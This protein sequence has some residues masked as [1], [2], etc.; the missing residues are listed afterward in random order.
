M[1]VPTL[2]PLRH[3][4]GLDG[5]TFLLGIGGMKC[6]TSW[7]FEYLSGLD[8]MTASDIKELHFFN[9]KLRKPGHEPFTER[10]VTTLRDFLERSG[11]VA[12]EIRGNPPF[13]ATVDGLRMLHDDN[14]YF[15]YFARIATPDTKVLSEV[16]PQYSVLGR[17]GFTYIKDFFASQNMNL[18]IFLILRDPV[19]RLWSH[20]R[21]L[22]DRGKAKD[23]LAAWPELIRQRSVIERSDYWQTIEGLDA[24]FPA[25]DVLCLFYED[26]FQGDAL[27]SLCDFA[28]VVYQPPQSSVRQNETMVKADLPDDVRQTLLRVLKPQYQ[29]CRKRFGDAVPE[30]WAN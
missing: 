16:T 10:L 27:Q 11:D 4:P 29:F 2:G 25:Q 9:T 8:G 21:H 1:H 24:V 19:D 18:K 5:K 23:I 15:D 12:E 13:Q 20:L 3:Y 7:V 6:A 28:G 14:A 17:E 26:L 22:Q 30:T